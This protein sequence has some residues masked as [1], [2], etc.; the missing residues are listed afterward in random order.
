MVVF[1]LFLAYLNEDG[2]QFWRWGHYGLCYKL[3][4]YYAMLSYVTHISCQ[5][6]VQSFFSCHLMT[7]A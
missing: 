1:L 6:Q 4:C 7:A 3:L 2:K 5:V